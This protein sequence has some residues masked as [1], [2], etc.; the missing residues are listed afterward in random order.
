ME[1]SVAQAELVALSQVAQ[2]LGTRI[3][4]AAVRGP[5]LAAVRSLFDRALA[6]RREAALHAAELV[7]LSGALGMHL[8]L[9]VLQN[10]FWQAVREGNWAHDPRAL[11]RLAHALWFDEAVVLGRIQERRA[12]ASA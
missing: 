3:D 6:G 4:L 5:Y 2:R 11:A 8:D 9:W 10:A 7:S 1:P 12:R